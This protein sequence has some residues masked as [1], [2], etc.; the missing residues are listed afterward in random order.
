[1]VD[2]SVESY[3]WGITWVGTASGPVNPSLVPN[4][5]NKQVTRKTNAAPASPNDNVLSVSDTSE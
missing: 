4:A 2:N 5:R 3:T 1:M